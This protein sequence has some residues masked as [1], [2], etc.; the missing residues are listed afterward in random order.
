MKFYNLSIIFFYLA[1]NLGAVTAVPA[2]SPSLDLA[3][4]VLDDRTVEPGNSMT[5]KSYPSTKTHN[6]GNCYEQIVIDEQW[7]TDKSKVAA[8]H[9]EK[10]KQ[11]YEAARRGGLAV[12][13]ADK[14][15]GLSAD[16]YH[17]VVSA[18]YVP[19]EGFIVAS[20]FKGAG[21][22]SQPA[23]TCKI[24]E[25]GAH[26]FFANCAEIN[27]LA[28]ME[29]EKTWSPP[30][31]GSMIAAWNTKSQKFVDPCENKK[32][33]GGEWPGC[34]TTLKEPKWKNIEQL[35]ASEGNSKH[36]S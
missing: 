23:S 7:D 4:T 3:R 17:S 6:G 21:H 33:A 18:T 24:I 14:A 25:N 16:D 19:M 12:I 26:A 9:E 30:R 10:K 36:N 27:T 13:E 32:D 2:A 34:A 22:D 5:Y 15:Q 8:Q 11:V 29:R 1:G 20:S 31:E 28:I 35:S